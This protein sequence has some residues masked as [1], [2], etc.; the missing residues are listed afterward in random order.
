MHLHGAGEQRDDKL[1]FPAGYL[2]AYVSAGFGGRMQ[3]ALGK[4]LRRGI[5]RRR[6]ERL[7]KQPLVSSDVLC[8]VQVPL[9]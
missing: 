6:P 8:T 9:L 5:G 3:A 7:G 2:S 1:A 4:Q